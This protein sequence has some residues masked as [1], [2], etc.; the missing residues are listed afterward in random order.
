MV[1]DSKQ[2][3]DEFVIWFDETYETR[4]T[5]A[6]GCHIVQHYEGKTLVTRVIKHE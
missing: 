4:A 5:P 3:E 1:F 2:D 6:D